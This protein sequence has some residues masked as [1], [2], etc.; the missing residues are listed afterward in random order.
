MWCMCV[1]VLTLGLFHHF[2]NVSMVCGDDV[3]VFRAFSGRRAFDDCRTIA[4]G[5]NARRSNICDLDGF[6]IVKTSTMSVAVT[7]VHTHHI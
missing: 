6:D 3:V 4:D 7:L 5:Q 1:R 2:R